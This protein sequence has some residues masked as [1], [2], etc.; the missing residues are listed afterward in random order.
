M[1]SEDIVKRLV[2]LQV[3]TMRWVE[4]NTELRCFDSRGMERL[5]TKNK[6]TCTYLYAAETLVETI[7]T[8][9]KSD[10][11]LE[12]AIKLLDIVK[13]SDIREHRFGYNPQNRFNEEEDR[14]DNIKTIK[15][16]QMIGYLNSIKD[17]AKELKLPESRI[18][19]ACQQERLLNTKKVGK[20]W[21][22]DKK[23]CEKY[24]NLD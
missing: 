9:C 12:E 17:V 22:V 24:W 13:I 21:L 10:Y 4:R 20:T 15:A 3:Y 2:E 19:Q 1:K 8:Y 7:K 6:L 11:L 18:K 14:L 23:E 5:I 16:I